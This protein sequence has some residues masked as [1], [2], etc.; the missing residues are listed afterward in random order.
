MDAARPYPPRLP[1]IRLQL[2]RFVLE[3]RPD[4]FGRG[5]PGGEHDFAGKIEGW[6][7]LVGSGLALERLLGAF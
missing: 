6:I 5:P 1:E 7:F 2:G 3:H 4:E